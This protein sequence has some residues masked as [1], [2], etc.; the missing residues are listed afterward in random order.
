MMSDYIEL[1]DERGNLIV[2]CKADVDGNL[3]CEYPESETFVSELSTM[4]INN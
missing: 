2:R 4:N 1:K 3:I